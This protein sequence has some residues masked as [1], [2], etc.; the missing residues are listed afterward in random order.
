MSLITSTAFQVSP[1][2]Q[3]RAFIA[4]GA[5]INLEVDDD[6]VYQILV[7]LNTALSKHED[8]RK[9]PVVSIIR[10]LCK[11]VPALPKTSRYNYLLFWLA[12]TLLQ[13][14]EYNVYTDATRLLRITLENME[15]RGMF[16]SGPVSSILLKCRT[17][18]EEVTAELDK[19]LKLSF[20][21][22]FSFSLAAILFKGIRYPILRGAAEAALRALLCVTV[23]SR[24]KKDT[25]NG[26]RDSVPPDAL[27]YFLALLPVSTTAET[28]RQL[29]DDC[30]IDEA[31]LPD[32]GLDLLGD[33]ESVAPRISPAFLGVT[34]S[35]T[36]LL[37]TSL[38]STMLNTSQG[39]DTESEMLFSLLSETANHF[40][41]TVTLAYAACFFFGLARVL[42]ICI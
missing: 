19:A 9:C 40:P 21:S 42:M 25:S 15:K 34:D 3:T 38:V 5:L 10:C 28:Y 37:V 14:S 2:I 17:P 20:E 35:N 33:G 18:L 29:L 24:R 27:G 11:I 39:D 6:Y 22:S 8:E 12:V 16:R 1:T 4:L 26:F 13:A 31:W 32:A 7:A 23:R 30:N 41:Q 36:A